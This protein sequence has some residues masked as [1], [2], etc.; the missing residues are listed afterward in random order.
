[1][2]PT[3]RR[4]GVELESAKRRPESLGTRAGSPAFAV[5]KMPTLPGRRRRQ[6]PN[7]SAARN[8]VLAG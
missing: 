5:G 7:P 4:L 2:V 8:S 3:R 6:S 1:M